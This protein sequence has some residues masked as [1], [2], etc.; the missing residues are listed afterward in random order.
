[1][2]RIAKV[3]LERQPHRCRPVAERRVAARDDVG[4]LG[5]IRTDVDT[6]TGL[7]GTS[8]KGDAVRA[9][10]GLEVPRGFGESHAVVVTS[11]PN[12]ADHA[13]GLEEAIMAPGHRWFEGVSENVVFAGEIRARCGPGSEAENC[14]AVGES[15]EGR[16][17]GG[18]CS[19]ITKTHVVDEHAEIHVRGSAGD[20]SE[21]NVRVEHVTLC[22][23]GS[24]GCEM[25]E[26]PHRVVGVAVGSGGA[27]D[28]FV[29]GGE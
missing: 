14:A 18:D 20:G 5:M 8:G 15:V 12:V 24:K 28:D 27:V 25:V 21:K 17:G 19:G 11:C 22:F 6:A 2:I 4:E 13:E 3:G 9:D 10:D 23:V 1:M 26:Y 29:D 7:G 16:R